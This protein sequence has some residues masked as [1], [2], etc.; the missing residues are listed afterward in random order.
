MTIALATAQVL[1]ALLGAVLGVFPGGY[2]LFAAIMTITDGDSDKATFPV[3]WQLIAL[4]LATVLA[5][6]AL[7]A[8][9]PTLAAAVR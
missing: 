8:V 9:P 5:V 2:L 3:P 4:I 7:A 6:A 1:P